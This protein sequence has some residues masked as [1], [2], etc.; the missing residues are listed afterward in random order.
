MRGEVLLNIYRFFDVEKESQHEY[1]KRTAL[2]PPPPTPK[3][4]ITH[5]LSPPSGI[6]A[7][8]LL[9]NAVVVV[10][11][12]P[13][14]CCCDCCSINMRRI[15]PLSRRRPRKVRFGPSALGPSLNNTLP[16]RS[17]AAMSMMSST[18]SSSIGLS[19]AP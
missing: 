14:D 16:W 17:L 2:L 15:I 4:L 7:V 8:A 5:G 19:D 10:V 13:A 1:N 12:A 6:N 18:W 3:T 9:A 11:E